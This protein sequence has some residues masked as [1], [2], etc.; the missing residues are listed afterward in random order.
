MLQSEGI[1]STVTS[2]KNS[3]QLDGLRPDA[4]YVVQVRARTVA[5]YGQY[6]HP[7]EF[8]TTSERGTCTPTPSLPRPIPLSSC[9]PVSSPS[10]GS[11]AQQLQEQLPLIVGSATAGLVFVVAVV[12]IAVVCLRYSQAHWSFPLGPSCHISDPSPTSHPEP[13]SWAQALLAGKALQATPTT[14]KSTGRVDQVH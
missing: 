14:T 3:V 2:Q 1:A 9:S 7:A 6:S 10:P 8:E 12:V 13:P 4:R 11:G 5:G